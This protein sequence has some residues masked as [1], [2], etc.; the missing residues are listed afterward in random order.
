VTVVV[1][2]HPYIALGAVAISHSMIVRRR[3][4]RNNQ[5]NSAIEQERFLIRTAKPDIRR[6]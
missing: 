6:E 1:D 5:V 3:A 4:R 2:H